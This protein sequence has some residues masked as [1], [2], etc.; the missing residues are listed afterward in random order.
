MG[1][2]RNR[3]VITGMGVVSPIGI[4]LDNYWTAVKKGTNGIAPITLFDTTDCKIKLAAELK[5]FDPKDYLDGRAARRLE[6][7]AQLGL[8]ASNE[9]IKDS[10]IDMEKEDPYRVG[11][12]VGCGVGS[13]QILEIN[14]KN[15]LESGP[16]GVAPLLIPSLLTNM[17]AANVSIAHG[18]RGKCIN[19][20]TACA[21]GNYSI[22]EAFRSIQCGDADVMISGGTEAPHTRLGTI[23]FGALNANTPVE[24]PQRASI[25]FDKER[26]GFVMGEGAGVVILENLDH[27][28]ARKAKIYAE[29]VG[30]GATS[31]AFH[32]TAPRED[33][34]AALKAMEFA[35]KDGDVDPSKIDY[36]NA[37][38][39]STMYND[40]YETRAIKTLFKEHAK[41]LKVN[42]TKSMIGHLMGAAGAVEFITTA[43]SVKNDFVHATINHKVDDEELD[44]NYMFKGGEA[45]TVN[46]AMTNSFGFGGHNATLVLKKYKK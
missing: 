34:D 17:A 8:I 45:C 41:K 22:G 38:G 46:Y 31:D 11:T 36:I 43:L 10:G 5:N 39:T 19:V 12:S 9:A 1:I 44:L 23:A 26:S 20:A 33:G 35:L 40:L 30:Y 16:K 13:I 42:S 2:K 37:H 3:V 27:A 21:T 4:G 24:D 28:L 18:A 14:I 7:F 32:I 6:R 29:V 25:P 15:L